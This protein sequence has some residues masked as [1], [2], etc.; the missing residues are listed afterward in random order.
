MPAKYLLQRREHTGMV[1]RPLGGKQHTYSKWRTIAKFDDLQSGSEAF[2][3]A[4][5]LYGY[6]LTYRGK[7]ID[8]KGW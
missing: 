4:R 2:R 5:G 7:T 3:K 6:R 1:P 8:K